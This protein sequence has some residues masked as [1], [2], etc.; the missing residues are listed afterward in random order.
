MSAS[1]SYNKLLRKRVKTCNKSK[2]SRNT[3]VATNLAN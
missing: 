1:Q 2:K 3:A